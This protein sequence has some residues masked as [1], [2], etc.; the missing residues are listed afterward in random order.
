MVNSIIT[1]GKI[2]LIQKL[3]ETSP[4]IKQLLRES[5]D[6]MTAR[7][8][9]FMYLND[10][11]RSYYNVFSDMPFRTLNITERNNAKECIR[12]IKNIIRTENEQLCNFSALENLTAIAHDSDL[13]P[14]EIS[15]GFLAEFIFLFLGIYGQTNLD[16]GTDVVE[17]SGRDSARIRS[18]KL[19]FYSSQLQLHFR[20]FSK[21]ADDAV[22]KKR[23]ILKDKILNY[24]KGNESDWDDYKWHL[25]HIIK[26][27]QTLSDLVTLSADEKEGVLS[28]N[29]SHIPFQITPYYLSL[30][31]MTGRIPEDTLLR[32]MVIP[33]QKYCNNI[34]RNK[35]EGLDMDFMGERSTSPIDGITRRY[36][37]ILILKPFDSCPQICVYCQRNWE[38]KDMDEGTITSSV[39]SNAIDWIAAHPTISEVL[40]TGGDPLTLPDARIGSIIDRVAAI[41]HV[42]RIRI[43][44]RMLVTVPQRFT[45]DLIDIFAKYHQFGT[46]EIALITHFESPMEI[47]SETLIA[48]EKIRRKG[49]NIYNQQVFTY[50]N[51]KRFETCYLRKTLKLSGIEPYYTFN[52]KGKEET[53]EFRV[54]IAR[55]EQERKEEARLLPGIVRTDEPVFNVPK[56]GKSHLRSWQDHEPIM[57][58]GN[59]QRVY[60]FYPWESRISSVDDYLYTDVSIYDYL[61]R[62]HQDG[63]NIDEYW[64]IWY[65]F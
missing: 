1:S 29:E 6:L 23:R 4:E 30:F 27:H 46:R 21:G 43:G 44:T 48:I 60:R 37:Q 33:S 8:R 58:M 16:K 13:I 9:L 19:D 59:G 38:I 55:I 28:A 34:I 65:Y 64:S 35:K 52:T 22:E 26:D 15:E 31:N 50:Y 2:E 47:T 12:V 63:E 61:R 7:N 41:P 49:I 51:S 57:I 3:W 18:E 32:S 17:G 62:L 54:P 40:I 14:D 25:K 53:V 42:E 39:I 24:F 45:D 10:L 56:L 20:R 5:V 11:E 36:P